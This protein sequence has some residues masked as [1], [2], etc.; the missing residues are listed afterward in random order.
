MKYTV[1]VHFQD[2]EDQTTTSGTATIEAYNEEEALET[3]QDPVLFEVEA[4]STGA[5][6]GHHFHSLAEY[7]EW[8]KSATANELLQY[9]DNLTDWDWK[10]PIRLY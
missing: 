4:A 10:Q 5:T 2:P 7:K 9:W 8:A 1:K 6:N 3:A